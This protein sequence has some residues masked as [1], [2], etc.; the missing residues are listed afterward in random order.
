MLWL[1]KLLRNWSL[2]FAQRM[3]AERQH[4][5]SVSPQET[6]CGRGRLTVWCYNS[7]SN[8]TGKI[9]TVSTDILC[10][11]NLAHLWPTLQITTGIH[12][13]KAL[14]LS[15]THL[16]LLMQ[17]LHIVARLSPYVI[18]TILG[19][20]S[21]VGTIPALVSLCWRHDNQW[22]WH[23]DL[24]HNWDMGAQTSKYWWWLAAKTV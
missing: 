15:K 19:A 18:Q 16:P 22:C 20:V 7:F 1:K 13:F 5:W 9:S 6:S 10:S 3:R 24:G 14:V 11:S 2:V 12:S 21:V 4:G 23:T 8:S 17:A